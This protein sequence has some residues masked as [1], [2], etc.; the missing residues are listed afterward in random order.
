MPTPSRLKLV[1]NVIQYVTHINLKNKQYKYK[2]S[3]Y[4]TYKDSYIANICTF[5][6]IYSELGKLVNFYSNHTC[7]ITV[8]VTFNGNFIEGETFTQES[9]RSIPVNSKRRLIEII[10]E[11]RPDE[12]LNYLDVSG[13]TDMSGVFRYSKFNGK[14]DMWDVSNVT[15]TSCMFQ[16]SEFNGDISNWNTQNIRRANHM[17]S[18]SKFNG[19][20]T[21]WDLRSLVE[22]EY[23]FG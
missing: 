9:L 17:F 8:E 20:T 16:H 14:I 21:K 18:M 2:F 19:D 3:L 5:D 22:S 11:S 10:N 7:T 6:E 13:I 23:M 4:S 12:D 1:W 15:D